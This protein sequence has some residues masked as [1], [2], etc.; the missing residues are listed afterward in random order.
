M[1]FLGGFFCYTV[2][3]PKLESDLKFMCF[4]CEK[5]IFK[6]QTLLQAK[7]KQEPDLNT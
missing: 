6:M 2:L 1:Y 7:Y 4:L 5:F 3:F